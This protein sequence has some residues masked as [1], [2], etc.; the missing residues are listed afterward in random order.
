MFFSC[1]DMCH[2]I[3]IIRKMSS[4]FTST[5]TLPCYTDNLVKV[6]FSKYTFT[7]ERTSIFNS[8]TFPSLLSSPNLEVQ[9]RSLDGAYSLIM[10]TGAGGHQ[11]FQVPTLEELHLIS[12]YFGGGETPLHKPYIH[13][14]YIP[15]RIPPF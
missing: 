14:A 2:V 10:A 3:Q 4:N 9:N 7:V 11:T 13:T 6:K 1:T 15:V 8:S 5:G 12:G